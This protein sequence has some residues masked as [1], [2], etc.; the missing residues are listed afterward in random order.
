LYVHYWRR[1]AAEVSG[2]HHND[3]LGL[4]IHVGD[5]T[6]FVDSGT[7]VYTADIDER[8]RYRSTGVHSTIQVDDIEINAFDPMVPFTMN[9]EAH[10]QVTQWS[11]RGGIEV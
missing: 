4:E 1:W 2:H 10:P 6:L 9:C 7:Y 8:N 3:S 11:E 5:K